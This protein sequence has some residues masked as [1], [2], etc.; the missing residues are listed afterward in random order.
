MARNPQSAAERERERAH[1]IFLAAVNYG[2]VEKVRALLAS[3]PIDVNYVEPETG[4]TASHIAAGRGAGAVIKL[5][6][7]TGRCDFSIKDR[8]GRT[9]ATIAVTVGRDPALGRYLFDLQYGCGVAIARRRG[10]GKQEES[11]PNLS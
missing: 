10:S 8:T 11:E 4:F 7:A 1:K 3:A 2:D 9:A 5:L 6:A